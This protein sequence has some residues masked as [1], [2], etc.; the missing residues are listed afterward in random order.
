[1]PPPHG[2]LGVPYETLL[3]LPGDQVLVSDL[4]SNQLLRFTG[5]G[6][7]LGRQGGF[8]NTPGQFAGIGALALGRDGHLYVTD[9]DHRVVQRFA[10]DGRIDGLFRGPDDDESD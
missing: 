4:N 7:L 10:P 5:D 2:A 9:S 8:G 6:H 1:L 3:A